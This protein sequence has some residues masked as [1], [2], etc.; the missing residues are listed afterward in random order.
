ML[1]KMISFNE[2]KLELIHEGKLVFI[3]FPIASVTGRLTCFPPAVSPQILLAQVSLDFRQ[4]PSGSAPD[5]SHP[6]ICMRN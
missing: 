4:L 6:Y 5:V 1:E 3:D 2:E